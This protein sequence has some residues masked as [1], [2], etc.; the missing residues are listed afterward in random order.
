M[1]DVFCERILMERSVVAVSKS[2]SFSVCQSVCLYKSESVPVLSIIFFPTD[3][4]NLRI[5]DNGTDSVLEYRGT[6]YR[7]GSTTPTVRPSHSISLQCLQ[8][9]LKM[10][11]SD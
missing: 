6:H 2:A 11:S 4:A 9:T 1:F 5:I 3:T 10:L 8:I 7:P